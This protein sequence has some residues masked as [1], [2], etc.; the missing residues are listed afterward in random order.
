M[1]EG[2]MPADFF[3]LTPEEQQI[4]LVD[5]ETLHE[6]E[7]LIK[8]CKFCNKELAEVPLRSRNRLPIQA[9]GAA[10]SEFD[11]TLLISEWSITNS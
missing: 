6:A 10:R 7:T 1:K 11:R 3:D 4:I 8:S 2:S 9:D 5:A